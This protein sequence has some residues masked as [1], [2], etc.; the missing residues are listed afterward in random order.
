M[1]LRTWIPLFLA[2]LAPGLYAW[3]PYFAF[4]QPQRAAMAELLPALNA[5]TP[6]GGDLDAACKAVDRLRPILEDAANG[7]PGARG[8]SVFQAALAEV[9]EAR[10]RCRE[11]PRPASLREQLAALGTH[12][13]VLRPTPWYGDSASGRTAAAR[14]SLFVAVPAEIFAL[15][16][17]LRY[18]RRERRLDAVD[19]GV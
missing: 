5:A 4:A 3:Y 13:G 6:P 17:I 14:L 10:S 8:R 15:L 2:L 18:R 9:E 12:L 1:K 11:S 16:M 19:A 7:G